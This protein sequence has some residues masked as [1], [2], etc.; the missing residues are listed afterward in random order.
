MGAKDEKMGVLVE[1]RLERDLRM[2]KWE[3]CNKNVF[4]EILG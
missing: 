3:C 1:C 2:R 4:N